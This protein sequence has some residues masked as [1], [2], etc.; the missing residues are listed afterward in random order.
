MD[1]HRHPEAKSRTKRV[2]KV[3]RFLGTCSFMKGT[4]TRDN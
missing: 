2:V 1:K 4:C 3:P